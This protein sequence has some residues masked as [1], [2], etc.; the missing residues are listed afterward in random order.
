MRR[1][2][3]DFG[4]RLQTQ[5]AAERFDQLRE[6]VKQRC[7][8][9]VQAQNQ[10]AAEV[11]Q[12]QED[13]QHLRIE[14]RRRRAELEAQMVDAGE[15]SKME[16]KSELTKQAGLVDQTLTTWETKTKQWVTEY[17]AAQLQPMF[18]SYAE[19]AVEMAAMREQMKDLLTM[20][21][22]LMRQVDALMAESEEEADESEPSAPPYPTES[23]SVQDS[24]Q[25]RCS[26]RRTSH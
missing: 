10:F 24:V 14:S 20:Q 13:V 9:V 19:Q 21:G 7:D 1:R 17:L 8:A 2:I 4:E 23:R 3:A 12:T 6:E 15:L 11:A 26:Q 5:P 25:S 18:K 16:L 22:T